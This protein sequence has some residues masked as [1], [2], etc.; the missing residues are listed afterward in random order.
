MGKRGA[1]LGNKK[2]VVLW[3]FGA[4]NAGV[5]TEL[6]NVIQGIVGDPAQARND[7]GHQAKGHEEET[8]FLLIHS[9]PQVQVESG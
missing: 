8:Q 5:H 6:I 2:S 9:I 4:Y 7:G 3:A 1:R